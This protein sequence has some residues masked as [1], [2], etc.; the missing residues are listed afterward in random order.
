MRTMESL[1]CEYILVKS[2][3]KE[4]VNSKNNEKSNHLPIYFGF[5]TTGVI[6]ATFYG[7]RIL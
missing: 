4:S 7:G 5:K 1:S 3:Q 2:T 6:L